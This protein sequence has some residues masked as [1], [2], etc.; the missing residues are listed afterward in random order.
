MG[1][2]Q[3]T[4]NEIHELFELADTMTDAALAGTLVIVRNKNRLTAHILNWLHRVSEAE[5][6]ELRKAFGLRE[7]SAE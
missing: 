6:V 3:L 4:L 2:Q 5:R 1:G 7:N